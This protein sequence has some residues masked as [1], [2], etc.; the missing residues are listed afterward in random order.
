MEETSNHELNKY[1]T[2]EASWEHSTDMQH[3]EERLVIRDTES[4][5]SN[6]TPHSTATF[7]ATD[8]GA[9]YDGDGSSWN[10]AT[11]RL[12]EINID[13][14][15]DGS[16]TSH[17]GELADLSDI[18]DD[19]SNLTNRTHG[20]ED[21]SDSYTTTSPGDVDSTNWGDYEIQKDGTDGAG[22]INFK[23]N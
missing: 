3:I 4:N 14:L 7:I 13:D 17:T 5:M 18:V 23:T 15:I 19:Y 9:V 6:Y 16:G 20:N 22:V 10:L 12:T 11:R 2:G 8:T 21:H 1:N